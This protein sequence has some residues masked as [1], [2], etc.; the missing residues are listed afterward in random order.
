M[1]KGFK[2]T[3]L[4]TQLGTVAFSAQAKIGHILERTQA[5]KGSQIFRGL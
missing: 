5:K 1:Y 3:K 4:K 2:Y